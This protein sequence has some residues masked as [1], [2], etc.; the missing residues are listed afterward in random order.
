LCQTIKTRTLA[1]WHFG[2]AWQIYV[3][4]YHIACV[5]C[6]RGPGVR[7]VELPRSE[8]QK[9]FSASVNNFFSCCSKAALI[10][11]MFCLQRKVKELLFFS[12]S[13]EQNIILKMSSSWSNFSNFSNL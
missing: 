8:G 9:V 5:C 10:F 6:Q 13:V 11:E 12:L 7:N 4:Q 1:P 2:P 3:V